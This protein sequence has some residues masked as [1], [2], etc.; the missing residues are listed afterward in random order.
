MV[1][2]PRSVL[3]DVLEAR[4]TIPNVTTYVRRIT[5]S[6]PTIGFNDLR[7][8]PY[9]VLYPGPGITGPDE[10]L[11]GDRVGLADTFQITCAC[12]DEDAMD[13]LIDAVTSRF[14]E[15]RP[16][17]PSPYDNVTVGRCRMLNDVGPTRRDDDE[18]PPRFWVP[19]VYGFI[20]NN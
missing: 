12:G 3:T 7:V 9:V 19:L 20:V 4:A 5:G 13:L 1:A 17:L 16:T 14:D 6:P 11:G 15:W 2:V 8:K 10:R 18:K